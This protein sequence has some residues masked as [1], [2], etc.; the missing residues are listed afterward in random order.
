MKRYTREFLLSFADSENCRRPPNDLDPAVRRD[1]PS[2]DL[3]DSGVS[4]GTKFLHRRDR[5]FG[6]DVPEW[7]NRN[8]GNGG[9]LL[10]QG[11]ARRKAYDEEGSSFS[12]PFRASG[13]RQGPGQTRWD[14][15]SSIDRE[16]ERGGRHWDGA[17]SEHDGLL[18]SGGGLRGAY[19]GGPDRFVGGGRGS[20]NNAN[21]TRPNKFSGG[22]R[23]D[24]D[25]IDGETFGEKSS[26]EDREEEERKRRESFESMRKEQQ[27]E[28]KRQEEK[29]R[30]DD[31][32]VLP[33][34][35]NAKQGS[36]PLV[37]PGFSKKTSA[38]KEQ[39]NEEAK[40]EKAIGGDVIPLQQSSGAVNPLAIAISL[41]EAES[42]ALTNDS[43]NGKISNS[44]GAMTVPSS[45]PQ[46]T[47]KVDARLTRTSSKFAHLF[48]FEDDN[49]T[50]EF[51]SLFGSA[52][53]T[54]KDGG[55]SPRSP[56]LKSSGMKPSSE[57]VQHGLILP[58]PVGPSLEDIE[59]GF[60]NGAGSDHHGSSST[61]LTCEDIEQS[62]L[63]EAKT[64]THNEQLND[65]WGHSV[66]KEADTDASRHLLSLLQ[67][68]SLKP[69]NEHKAPPV[70][71]K[72]C[73]G[74]REARDGKESG[75]ATLEA[76][77]G[78][79]FMMELRSTDAPLS[80]KV[81]SETN[82]HLLP[83]NAATVPEKSNAAS[84]VL[85]GMYM[86]TNSHHPSWPT[87]NKQPEVPEKSSGNSQ[88][89]IA[90]T[91]PGQELRK[92]PSEELDSGVFNDF[93][94]F[95][96][97]MKQRSSKANDPFLGVAKDS[98]S[99]ENSSNERPENPLDTSSNGGG[100]PAVTTP[101]NL[102]RSHSPPLIN[103]KSSALQLQQ[104]Q[105]ALASQGS[106]ASIQA[107]QQAN[108]EASAGYSRAARPSFSRQQQQALFEQ[109]Q[110]Q[111]HA[112][113]FHQGGGFAPPPSS[114]AAFG[115]HD[116][117]HH[118]LYSSKQQQRPHSFFPPN[119]SNQQPPLPPLAS[120][121]LPPGHSAPPM[122]F[123]HHPPLATPGAFLGFPPPND[124]GFLVAGEIA[125]AAGGGGGGAGAGLDARWI[126]GRD[127]PIGLYH[128]HHQQ[129]HHQQSQFGA[130]EIGFP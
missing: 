3:V 86:N 5:D 42:F 40:E 129:Q 4:P 94:K 97:A 58:M 33:V 117:H 37:P 111:L 60:D 23:N 19:P 112:H 125:A 66:A 17:A 30:D 20:R 77:F 82:N 95:K 105:Q 75:A 122:S 16:R 25:A 54:S 53:S 61:F 22:Y 55:Q 24:L 72:P 126:P 91:S 45:S 62:L 28:R 9:G 63:A 47:E 27:Q 43:G 12:S 13:S 83:K 89:V 84:E 36:R 116:L 85:D 80:A 10:S 70:E 6:H 101:A 8:S 96:K 48:S 39:N 46:V 98:G 113:H 78:M 79:S 99:Q 109:Q 32:K 106:R 88:H 34:E 29:K 93:L 90:D 21:D 87:W 74:Q 102:Y 52:G 59:K 71:A 44:T 50:M 128:H 15:R 31:T 100:S 81:A 103:Q 64:E 49:S 38:R 2:P 121:H 67:K 18:G 107:K 115:H 26:T 1:S 51:L 104:L 68:A 127:H 119:G 92:Q 114:A 123:G 65:N 41:T 56:A 118:L 14:H 69:D 120:L 130:H 35:Q 124:A 76:L 11:P 108:G 57:V 73:D 7:R 110:Q